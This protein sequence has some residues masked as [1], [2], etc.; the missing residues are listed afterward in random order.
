MLCA[1]CKWY[2]LMV[3]YLLFVCFWEG[4]PFDKGLLNINELQGALQPTTPQLSLRPWPG[5]YMLWVDGE[6]EDVVN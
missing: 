5:Y 1:D 3:P 4:V 2:I 6:K